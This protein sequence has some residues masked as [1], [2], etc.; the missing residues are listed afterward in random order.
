MPARIDSAT[1]RTGV[2]HAIDLDCAA[3]GRDHAA[4]NLHQGRFACAV[5]ADDAD[6]LA[7]THLQLE[8]GER[9]DTRIN[10]AY[11]AQPQEWLCLGN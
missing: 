9:D 7:G 10:F 1:V 3:V 8:A 2:G 4:K 11:A 5:F 6:H